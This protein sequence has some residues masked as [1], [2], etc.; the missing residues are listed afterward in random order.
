MLEWLLRRQRGCW[1]VVAFFV[2][3]PFCFRIRDL[4]SMVIGHIQISS[5]LLQ[6][7]AWAV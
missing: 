5:Q 4:T 7:P 6:V 3:A 1:T 2:V